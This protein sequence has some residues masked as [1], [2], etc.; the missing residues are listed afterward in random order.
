MRIITVDV[1]ANGEPYADDETTRWTAVH[2]KG[3]RVI[4]VPAKLA[5]TLGLHAVKTPPTNEVPPRVVDLSELEERSKGISAAL[6]A[7]LGNLPRI[8]N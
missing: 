4:Q 1:D 3:A 2:V 8:I 7:A 6:H 5:K